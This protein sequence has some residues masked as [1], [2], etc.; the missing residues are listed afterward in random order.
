MI[1]TLNADEDDIDPRVDTSTHPTMT[2]RL[3][4]GAAGGT[5]ARSSSS[6][7]P[8]REPFPVLFPISIPILIPN[9]MKQKLLF[10]MCVK[11]LLFQIKHMKNNRGWGGPKPQ[12]QT[13]TPSPL[14]FI[15]IL[16][17][18]ALSHHQFGG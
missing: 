2:A 18:S 6:S 14:F 3:Q 4:P 17:R 11:E 9:T 5:F 13:Q 12:T 16:F 1:Q 10:A 7:S 15:P 8:P